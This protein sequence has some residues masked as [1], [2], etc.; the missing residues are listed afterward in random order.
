MWQ[1]PLTV[2]VN[3]S[4]VEFRTQNL[5]ERITLVLAATGLPSSRLEL[6]VTERVMI[7]D[8]HSALK[9]MTDLKALGVRLSMDDFGT[10]YSSLSYLRSFPFDGLKIDKSFIEDLTESTEGQCIVNA[11]V[12]LGRALS[13]TI[14]AEGVETAAQ[15]EQLKTFACDEAQGYFLGKPM[16]L[17]SL[18]QLIDDCLSQKV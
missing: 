1:M 4:P 14:T 17:E 18:V 2:S 13:L 5:V 6:E 8:A 16:P 11:I 10:G 15:L 3:I 7:E 9:I 12:G